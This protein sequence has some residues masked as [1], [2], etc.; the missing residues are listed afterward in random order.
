MGHPVKRRCLDNSG[1]CLYDAMHWDTCVCVCVVSVSRDSHYHCCPRCHQAHETHVMNN[2]VL[3]LHLSPFL[4]YPPTLFPLHPSFPLML[5]LMLNFL[6][7]RW[8]I[9]LYA[10]LSPCLVRDGFMGGNMAPLQ[11]S[12]EVYLCK[13]CLL[14]TIGFMSVPDGPFSLSIPPHKPTHTHTH[15]IPSPSVYCLKSHRANWDRAVSG[16]E[17]TWSHHGGKLDS[18]FF[19]TSSLC[20]P[21]S[22]QPPC[23]PLPHFCPPNFMSFVTLTVSW[24]TTSRSGKG[25]GR[26]NMIER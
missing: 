22:S 4:S 20:F 9:Q 21:A 5:P 1:T 2:G 15:F 8:S 17:E 6:Y 14:H 18:A 12:V 13:Q 26:E 24:C 23:L 3:F 16:A 7:L 19:S 10:A 11:R 25:Q